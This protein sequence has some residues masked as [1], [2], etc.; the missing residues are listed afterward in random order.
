MPGEP[1]VEVRDLRKNY[2]ALE[3]VRGVS[4][5]IERGEVFGLLGPNGAG[6][7]TTIEILEGLRSRDGGKVVVCGFDPGLHARQL[8]EK[9]GIQLQ[10]TALPDKIT[11]E[12]ALNLFR[13]FYQRSLRTEQLLDWF[14]LQ[15]KRK[16]HYDLLS[17][18][19]QQRLALALAVVND[20]E[21]VMFDE[22]TAGLDP[23]TRR[24]IYSLI[25][26]LREERRT[27]LLT[28]HYIEEAEQLCDRVAI[29]DR[30][31]II[32][33]GTPRAIIEQSRQCSRIEFI[34]RSPVDLTRLH[35][36]DCAEDVTPSDGGY[37]IRSREAPRTLMALMRM[38]IAENNEVIQ[39]HLERPSLE[40][41]FIELTGRSLRD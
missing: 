36:L 8:K 35:A 19:Q 21:M 6:K 31:K 15:E 39:V 29:V 4:F 37:R 10:Q 9:I 28:T 18:G 13:S 2:A 7:T 22:P 27:V 23:Q 17:G 20:P 33:S 12:E 16:T 1:I 32:A 26:R 25:G 40:D 34:P 24:E 11:V 38:L 30:G 3:A 14:G 5:E 41:V